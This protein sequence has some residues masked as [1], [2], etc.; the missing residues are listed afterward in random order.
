M[1]GETMSKKH[2]VFYDAL[3]HHF[4]SSTCS[5]AQRAASCRHPRVA[6]CSPTAVL[7]VP[8]LYEGIAPARLADL[9]AMLGP[10]LAKTPTGV[11]RSRKRCGGSRPRACMAAMRQVGALRRL[12]EGRDGRHDDRAP[13]VGAPRFRAGH[14][15]IGAPSL[16]A[17]VHSEPARAGCRPVCAAPNGHVGINPRRAPEPM[18]AERP[19]AVSR[20][21]LI[22]KYEQLQALVP[23]PGRQPDY[24]ACLAAFPALEHAKTTP[25]GAHHGEGDVDAYDD[26]DRCAARAA[27]VGRIAWRPGDRVPGRAAARHRE[28]RHDG[29]R[30]RYQCDRPSRPLAQ[31]RDRCADCTGMPA[32][33]SRCAK[34]SAG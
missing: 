6:R 14:S 33:R 34:R 26:G 32:C 10:S 27:R 13:E 18:N 20:G 9:K 25:Q 29:H 2:A 15:R 1:Y 3:P 5:I 24:H 23:A 30:S 12:R 31:G 16:G 19:S 4:S 11:A 21:V 17:A 8:V 28:A 7:S 22:M